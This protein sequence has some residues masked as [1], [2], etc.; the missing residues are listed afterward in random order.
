M[1]N[2]IFLKTAQPFP[3]VTPLF[4]ISTQKKKMCESSRNSPHYK[5]IVVAFRQ[6]NKYIVLSHHGFNLYFPNGWWCWVLFFMLQKTLVWHTVVALC[7]VN[8]SM[9]SLSSSLSSS[10]LQEEMRIE[11]KQ[12]PLHR[13]NIKEKEYQIFMLK[14]GGEWECIWHDSLV[15]ELGNWLIRCQCMRKETQEKEQVEKKGVHSVGTGWAGDNPQGNVSWR[16]PWGLGLVHCCDPGTAVP[17]LQVEVWI[18]GLIAYR[19]WYMPF[20][21]PHNILIAGTVDVL[22]E[23]WLSPSSQCELA[24]CHDLNSSSLGLFLSF[25]AN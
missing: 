19:I 12:W 24:I 5:Y 7:Y 21:L 16:P 15:S 17:S 9:S 6:S 8:K 4:C 3:R 22:S 13:R 20:L 25:I 14:C 11:L 23:D 2:L 18:L 10:F 1:V